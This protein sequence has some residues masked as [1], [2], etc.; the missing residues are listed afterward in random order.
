MGGEPEG[1]MKA[2]F[3]GCFQIRVA[4]S[5]VSQAVMVSASRENVLDQEGTSGAQPSFPGTPVSAN[6]VV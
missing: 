5:L 2:S 4:V 6:Y 3:L 1:R